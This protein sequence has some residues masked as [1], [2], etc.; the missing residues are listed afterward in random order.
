[1]YGTEITSKHDVT[2]LMLSRGRY[3]QPYRTL[4]SDFRQLAACVVCGGVGVSACCGMRIL[5]RL[6]GRFIRTILLHSVLL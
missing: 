3:G 6:S 2:V 4:V 1:M 5:S